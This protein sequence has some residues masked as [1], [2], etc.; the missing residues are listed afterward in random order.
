MNRFGDDI[1]RPLV[2]RSD[3]AKWSLSELARVIRNFDNPTGCW[4][5]TE[6]AVAAILTAVAIFGRYTVEEYITV[7]E[8]LAQKRATESGGV[9]LSTAN[10]RVAW[11][12]YFGGPCP[13]WGDVWAKV[14]VRALAR[15][16]LVVEET[17]E[18]SENRVAIARYL[19]DTHGAMAGGGFG[20]RQQ[21]GEVKA[22]VKRIGWKCDKDVLTEVE[23]L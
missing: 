6:E 22:D 15:K 10:A 11:G 16:P 8:V 9:E 2:E 5:W 4:Y 23:R 12:V 19:V 1:L 13:Q 14:L 21:V 18:R 17:S 20:F 7:E 3:E